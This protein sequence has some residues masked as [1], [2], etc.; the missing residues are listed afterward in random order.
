MCNI[1]LSDTST[2]M[3]LDAELNQEGKVTLS[4]KSALSS[5]SSK[6]DSCYYQLTSKL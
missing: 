5:S 2:A 4:G 6:Y 3:N 1:T